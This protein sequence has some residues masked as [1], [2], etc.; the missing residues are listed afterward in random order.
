M[1][2]KKFVITGSLSR[3][4]KEIGDEIKKF[5]GNLLTSISKHTDYLLSNEKDSNSSKTK[6]A[7]D[8]GVKLINE[9]DLAMLIN[10]KWVVKKFVAIFLRA[11]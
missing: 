1:N 3:P 4:R 5:G 6:K 7:K 2:G 9:E 11:F 10:K 8:L